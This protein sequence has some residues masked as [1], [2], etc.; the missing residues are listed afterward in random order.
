STL[1]DVSLQC[2]I[3]TVQTICRQKLCTVTVGNVIPEDAV[4]SYCAYW[5]PHMCLLAIGTTKFHL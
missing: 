1:F 2:H 3:Y 4:P 5:D